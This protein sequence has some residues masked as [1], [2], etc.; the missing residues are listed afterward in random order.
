[1]AEEVGEHFNCIVQR[2]LCTAKQANQRNKL[3]RSHCS[4]NKWVC[5]LIV[6][7]GSCENFV[8]KRWVDYL[9]LSVEE[10]PIPYSIGWVKK[11]PTVK[12]TEICRVPLSI[13]KHYS[14]DILCDV[15]DMDASHI[16]LG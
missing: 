12:V 6:D 11:G 13:G 3:F 9:G 5:N 14:S 8:S 1:M 16:L 4:V 7:S 15:I 2:V 10:H